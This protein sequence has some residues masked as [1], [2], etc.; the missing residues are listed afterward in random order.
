MQLQ[1]LYN[2]ITPTAIHLWLVLLLCSIGSLIDVAEYALTQPNVAYA[3]M[4]LAC[5][6]IFKASMLT[7]LYIFSRPYRYLRI[8]V[9]VI[10]GGFTLLSL[11]NGMCCLFY[12]FGISRKLL[13]IFA[14]TNQNE[15]MEFLPELQSKFT[16]LF[17]SLKFVGVALLFIISW[18]LLP[19]VSKKYLFLS[20]SLFSLWGA[21]Y[22]VQVFLTADFGRAN[23]LVYLRTYR[24]IAANLRNMATMKELQAQRQDMPDK[25]SA[26]STYKAQMIVVVIGESASRDHLSLYGYPLPTT[27]R[28][29]TISKGLY[30]FTDAVASSTS[31]AENM[32]RLLTFMTDEPSNKDWFDYPTLLQLF[33]IL[34]YRTY[35][36]SN[37]ERTGEMSNLSGILSCD[38][39]VVKY[40]GSQDSEDHYLS[41]Y[42]EILLP[43][44]KECLVN[45]D[46]L[47]LVFLHTMGSH[48]QYHNRYPSNQRK[49]RSKDIIGT[50]PRPWLNKS[51]R[52]LIANYDN[53]ILYTD[54]ILIE[55]INGIRDYDKPAIM[56]Y[57]SDHGED[58]YDDRDYR[59]RDPKFAR[60]PFLIYVNEPYHSSN[61]DIIKDIER[62]E[63]QS[64]S[65]SELPQILLHLTGS[66]YSYYD[67]IR[68]PL[69]PSFAPRTRYVDNKPF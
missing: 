38:A 35:W 26:E 3:I 17:F 30:V 37:Q 46:S 61:P 18:K 27:P 60:V 68:D 57:V 56:V 43:D 13:T 2:L 65:T 39:D 6:S 66:H 62:A 28:L 36:L 31:T 25:D 59:G 52:E 69:S 55:V 8:I 22:F 50:L 32:P 49:F 10:I 23:H 34:G 21:I 29:D 51:K 64:F 58:V 41:K 11:L 14:E 12:G 20:V 63:T 9:C 45:K 67:S 54:S 48:F 15:L 44:L 4:G 5:L 24:C 40:L 16:T 1:K 7:G 53:S 33:Q 42:D 47:Q 19:L